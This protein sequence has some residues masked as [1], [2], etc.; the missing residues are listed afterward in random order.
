MPKA[1][2]DSL[3]VSPI[4]I[5]ALWVEGFRFRM[6]A[7]NEP[8]EIMGEVRVVVESRVCFVQPFV[9][10]RRE[11]RGGYGGPGMTVNPNHA[12]TM[13]VP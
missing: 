3:V 10:L 11:K 1:G 9:S 7:G 6:V 13:D 4:D 5:L 8:Q 12:F 2:R